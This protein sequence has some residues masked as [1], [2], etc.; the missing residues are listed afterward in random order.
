MYDEPHRVQRSVQLQTCITI[1]SQGN[2]TVTTI[3]SDSCDNIRSAAILCLR[4][5]SEHCVCVASC[6]AWRFRLRSYCFTILVPHAFLY[7]DFVSFACHTTQPAC[8]AIVTLRYP[9]WS[10]VGASSYGRTLKDFLTEH[11]HFDILCHFEVYC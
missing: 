7:S 10:A 3:D 8:C 2:L 6:S 1:V 9:T 4:G 11:G 5:H